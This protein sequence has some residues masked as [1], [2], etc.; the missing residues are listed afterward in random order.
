LCELLNT[1]PEAGQGVHPWL[2]RV[3]RYLHRFHSP[4]EI[5]DILATR[6]ADCGREVEP[7]EIVD[8]VKNSGVCKWE[9]SGKT[10]SE[11]R[12]EWL[13]KPTI[14][15]VPAFEPEYTIREASRIR[16]GITP[17]WLKAHSPIP[18]TCSTGEYLQKIFERNEQVLLF[19]RYRSQGA[20]WPTETDIE[21]FVRIH[22]SAG[23]WF[24]CNPVDGKEHLNPRLAKNS[25]R[26]MESVTAWRHAV[27]ECDH[28]P[29]ERWLPIW[30]KILVQLPLPIV[31]IIDSAGKSVHAL[32]RVSCNSKAAWDAF[33]RDQLL[34]LVKLGAC[35]GSLSAVR[36]T[37]LPGCYRDDRLQ[38]LLYLSPEPDG[39]PIFN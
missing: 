39:T 15:R 17:E 35:H 33:K 25:R 38:E 4:D 34:P 18:V 13:A 10:A 8:A 32:V 27:L 29:K 28:E 9:P 23:A 16:E 1:C 6:V 26:S 31:S 22:W 30:L 7:H 19:G 2:F 37:R 14:K 12:A 5:C 36:L 24:L 3:A 20:L 21:A 11:R